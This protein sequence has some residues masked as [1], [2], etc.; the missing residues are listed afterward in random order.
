MLSTRFFFSNLMFGCT[1]V[2]LI[3]AVF[4][5]VNNVFVVCADVYQRLLSFHILRTPYFLCLCLFILLTLN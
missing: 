3:V 2:G 4:D 1:S 5:A